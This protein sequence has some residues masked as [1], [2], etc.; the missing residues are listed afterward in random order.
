MNRETGSEREIL[1][2]HLDRNRAA[3]VRS[4]AGLS[5]EQATRRLGPSAT[6][7]AGVLKHLVDVEKWW[8]AH[9]V[10]GQADTTFASSDDDPDGDFELGP[11]DSLASL[12]AQFEAACAASREICARHELT[13][14]LRLVRPGEQ[15][16]SLRWVYVHM[17][18]ELARHNGHL[19]IYREL[20]TGRTDQ[21]G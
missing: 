5:W 2:A 15:R 14:Q 6:S 9:Q 1:E 12:V 18:E 13:D 17:I 19:D 7:A 3:V 8:F 11:D 16:A 20:I 10:D 21:G 4:V